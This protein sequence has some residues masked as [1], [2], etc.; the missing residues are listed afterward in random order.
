MARPE[1]KVFDGLDRFGHG[2]WAPGDESTKACSLKSEGPLVRPKEL[3]P[4][5]AGV[6]AL[7]FFFKSALYGEIE[8]IAQS[9]SNFKAASLRGEGDSGPTL[10]LLTSGNGGSSNPE[11]VSEV[12]SVLLLVLSLSTTDPVR[13]MK[14]PIFIPL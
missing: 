12:L 4:V 8:D 7:L 6:R 3:S 13:S 5:D 1:E 14:S 11:Q 10:A 9:S 2:W